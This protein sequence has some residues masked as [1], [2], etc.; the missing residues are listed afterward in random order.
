MEVAQINKQ[1]KYTGEQ[2]S[3][4]MHVNHVEKVGGENCHSKVC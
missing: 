3:I 4:Y 1:M 2:K